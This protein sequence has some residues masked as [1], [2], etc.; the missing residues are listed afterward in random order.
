MVEIK[1]YGIHQDEEQWYEE[2][3][4]SDGD[5][6]KVEDVYAA[7][8]DILQGTAD[9]RNLTNDLIKKFDL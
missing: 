3:E 5:Y 1:R 2:V 4:E 8:T 9:Y 7:L 6:Y